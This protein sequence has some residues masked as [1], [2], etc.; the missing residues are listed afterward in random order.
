KGRTDQPVQMV[1]SGGVHQERLGRG[2]PTIRRAVDQHLAQNLRARRTARLARQHHLTALG[3][4]G[5]GQAAGLGRFAGAFAAFKGDE[6]STSHARTMASLTPQAKPASAPYLPTMDAS[7][8]PWATTP[9]R[10]CS[11]WLGSP[12]GPSMTR[13]RRRPFT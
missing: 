8:K 10:A 9:R 12:H 1:R 11:A 5:F 13:H 4:Q 6:P 7:E 2:G 3:A